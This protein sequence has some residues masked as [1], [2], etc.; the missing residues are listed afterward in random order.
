M[1]IID[2]GNVT[3]IAQHEALL[4]I[5]GMMKKDERGKRITQGKVLPVEVRSNV[6][7]WHEQRA[8]RSIVFTRKYLLTVDNKI[9]Y[10]C[11]WFP[12]VFYYNLS[13]DYAKMEVP[14]EEH[15]KLKFLMEQGFKLLQQEKP[16]EASRIGKS[17]PE[18]VLSSLDE[19]VVENG[20]GNIPTE[21]E[22]DE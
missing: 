7:P 18:G 20:D 8:F 21:E 11:K 17:M 1:K 5:T 3:K 14:A 19:K 15:N 2:E 12:V 22:L 10:G 4:L 9:R 6:L 13:R 16:E